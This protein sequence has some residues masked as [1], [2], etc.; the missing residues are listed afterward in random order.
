[1]S[2]RGRG[3]GR[4]LAERYAR[5]GPASGVDGLGTLTHLDGRLE[6]ILIDGR[7]GVRHAQERVD[8]AAASDARVVVVHFD[9]V[10]RTQQFAFCCFDLSNFKINFSV[11]QG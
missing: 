7:L 11:S 3:R 2:G 8:V 5:V 1:M 10:T 4:R 9:K 6:S